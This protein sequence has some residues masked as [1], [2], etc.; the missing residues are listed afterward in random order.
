MQHAQTGPE[1]GLEAFMP[2]VGGCTMY[3]DVNIV[4]K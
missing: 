1:D 2:C 4:R 3:F